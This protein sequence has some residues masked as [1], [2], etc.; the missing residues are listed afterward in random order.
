M[1]TTEEI[2]T[3]HERHNIAPESDLIIFVKEAKRRSDG[4]KFV[5]VHE[6]AV[7]TTVLRESSYFKVVFSSK[8]WADTGKETY[9]VKGDDPAAW[10]I[11]LQLLHGCIDE[12]KVDT[13]IST[14]W[15]L[16]VLALKYDFDGHCPELKQWFFAWYGNFDKHNNLREIPCRELLYPCYFFDHAVAFAAVTKYLVYNMCGHI[17][18]HMPNGV[19]PIQKEHHM[20]NNRVIGK[21][22][23]HS[24][25]FLETTNAVTRLA[26]CGTRQSQDQT[27]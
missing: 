15:N 2:P 3:E 16:L 23:H 6:F 13:R 21:A 14:I 12:A 26:Q 11:W 25:M 10:E 7:S 1:A 8:Q 22:S 19:E 20:A 5:C 9:E 27:S 4:E 17:E 24:Y 18:E